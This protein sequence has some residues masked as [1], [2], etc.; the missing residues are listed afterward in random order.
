MGL[1]SALHSRVRQWINA[2]EV[3]EATD[4]GHSQPRPGG[5]KFGA[6]GPI[7]SFEG[8]GACTVDITFAQVDDRSQFEVFASDLKNFTYTFTKSSRRF[9][10]TNCRLG[11]AGMRNNYESGDTSVTLQIMGIGPK[12]V[13]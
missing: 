5:Y 10:L 11:P 9:M 4:V 3:V 2:I 13:A 7:G 6:A 12:Q 8:Q 1:P